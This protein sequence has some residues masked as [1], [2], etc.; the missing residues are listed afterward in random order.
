MEEDREFVKKG[1]DGVVDG[2]DSS[3]RFLALCRVMIGK[4]LVTGKNATGFPHVTDGSY[5]SMYSP[6]LEEYKLLNENYVLPEFLVQYRFKGRVQGHGFPKKD[7]LN[8]APTSSN[9]SID[10]SVPF[11]DTCI[12]DRKKENRACNT[13]NAFPVTRNIAT[14]KADSSRRS[15]REKARS[16]Q[17][18]EDK[19]SSSLAWTSNEEWIRHRQNA[20]RQMETVIH[21]VKELMRKSAALAAE[22]RVPLYSDNASDGA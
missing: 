14:A 13:I 20:R 11:I 15:S 6:M 1:E 21:Q 2:A 19:G 3:I 22:L 4:I 12:F 18:R 5:D 8:A 16:S 7:E 10:L 9:F 17:G